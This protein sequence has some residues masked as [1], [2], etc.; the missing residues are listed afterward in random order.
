MKERCVQLTDTHAATS[1]GDVSLEGFYGTR[2]KQDL[3][4]GFSAEIK[5]LTAERA[6]N[7][8]PSLDTLVP[9]LKSFDGL[10]DCEIAATTQFDTDMN[11]L[12]PTMNGVIRLTG[13]NLSI[14]DNE[15]FT[16]LAKTFMFKN[17]KQTHV[18]KMKIEGIIKD[19]KLEVFPFILDIDRYILGLSG[20]QGLDMSYRYHVSLIKSP[21]LFKV[22]VD[23]YGDDFDNMK[24]KIGK[25][26][27]K[28]IDVPMFTAVIDKTK[29]NLVESIN[30]IFTKGV[31]A[32]VNENS[33]QIEISEHKEKIG[34]VQ[35]VEQS[36]E[37]LTEEEKKQVETELNIKIFEKK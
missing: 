15:Y 30:N 24:F 21:L 25:A 7:L 26:K 29:I 19:N 33:R 11:I 3:K 5:N 16:D 2:T 36:M 10:L 8:I 17:K 4:T 32:A 22:G 27:Y 37:E 34:Y 28:S 13:E 35:A 1:I 14:T 6:I 20:V 9:L 18:D 31:E 12:T 23:L